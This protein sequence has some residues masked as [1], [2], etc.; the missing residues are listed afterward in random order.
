MKVW[1]F[2]KSNLL[3]FV[4]GGIIFGSLSGVIAA[5]LAASEVQYKSNKTVKDAID[6]LY[7]LVLPG[8]TSYWYDNSGTE[9]TFP[10]YGGTLQTG[11]TAT[12]HNVYIG[13]DDTK[14][15]TCINVDGKEACLSQPYTQYIGSEIVNNSLSTEQQNAAKAAIGEVFS[16]V[17]IT[18]YSCYSN[19]NV[20][21]CSLGGF[22]C[23]VYNDGAV[24][25]NNDEDEYCF[26]YADGS[27]SCY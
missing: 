1:K 16:T 17:G 27:A 13:Q 7:K 10:N 11:G 19:E 18:G 20:A 12:G 9:Y 3:G 15:Y 23:D 25:C 26:V 14:Y 4:I 21:D 8:P 6:E 22:Y 5:S 2:I 24:T